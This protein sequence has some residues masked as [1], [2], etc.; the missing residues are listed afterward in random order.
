DAVEE[1]LRLEDVQNKL[2]AR[3]NE[4]DSILDDTSTP[5]DELAD[6]QTELASI[7]ERI[8]KSK[9]NIRRKRRALGF[10]DLQR[11]DRLRNDPY[12]AK[13][14]NA[15]ALKHRLKERLRARKFEL[16]R[17]ERAYRNQVNGK[18]INDQTQSSV[19]R[20]EPSIRNVAKQ[21]NAVCDELRKLI[22]QGKAPPGALPPQNIEMEGL[23][24]L[25]VDDAIWQDIGLDDESVGD[26]PAWLADDSVRD[27]IKAVL[28]H[29]RCVE[30]A[31]R[32][33][34]ECRS[35]RFW[36]SEEW[37]VIAAALNDD[38]NV[39]AVRYQLN[40]RR[41]FLIKLCWLWQET[42]TLDAGDVTTLPEWGPSKD[43]L[44]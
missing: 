20:R 3:A 37:K 43:D 29:D 30:E 1:I 32:L 44:T 11:L 25:D 7:R 21:Y 39:E 8:N 13:R 2:K 34:H 42:S 16:D 6:A 19:K 38:C 12:I 10:N 9:E 35:M 4:C 28:E 24:T 14:V 18:K 5:V 23:F 36:M 31:S 26:P 41:D 17:V 40:I 33:R 22:A 27:G 15:L